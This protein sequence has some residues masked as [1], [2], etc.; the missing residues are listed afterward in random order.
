MDKSEAQTIVI[1]VATK[2]KPRTRRELVAAVD[3]LESVV[4]KSSSAKPAPKK[5][6]KE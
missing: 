3:V 5:T 6:S 4:V 2:R 1:D